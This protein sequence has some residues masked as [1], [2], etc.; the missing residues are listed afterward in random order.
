MQASLASRRIWASQWNNYEILR[1]KLAV[2]GEVVFVT[3]T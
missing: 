2:E 1:D 3:G